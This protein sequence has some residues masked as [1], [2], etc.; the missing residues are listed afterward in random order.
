M[1]HRPASHTSMRRL[2]PPLATVT[3]LAALALA[4]TPARAEIGVA[5][6]RGFVPHQVVVKFEGERFA[7]GL[8][9]PTGTGVRRAAASLRENP[10]VA[11]AQPNYLAT[12][13]ATPVEAPPLLPNDSGTLGTG[14]PEAA[15]VAGDWSFKQ[16]NF[17][18]WREA[19]GTEQLFSPGG[20][21]AV[22]A[23]RNMEAIGRPGARG[24]TVAVLDTGAAYRDEGRRFRRSPDFDSNQF[25]PGRDFVD[26]DRLPLDE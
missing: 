8:A 26:D 13:S 17:L 23:W 11:Y 14:D 5:P 3:L 2:L 18:P 7:R 21:D 20:I 9:L 25:V 4:A 12:A 19:P 16:W 1:T 6:A 22:G 15:T 24:I 10:A